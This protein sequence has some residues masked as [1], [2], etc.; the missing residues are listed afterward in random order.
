MKTS[1]FKTNI[2]CTSCLEKVTPYL[3][4]VEG[5]TWKVDLADKQKILEVQSAEDKADQVK[6]SVREAGF[7]IE[8][9]P[10]GLFKKLFS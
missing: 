1:K 10:E 9:L 6:Q 7:Q 3:N 8:E 5:I 2:N 4:S